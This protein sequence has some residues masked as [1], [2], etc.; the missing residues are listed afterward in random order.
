[1]DHEQMSLRRAAQVIGCSPATLSRLL[2][3]NESQYDPDTATLEAVVHWL[4][5][6]LSDFSPTSRPTES[7]LADV[8]MHLHALPN[9][10]QEDARTLMAVVKALY[11]QRRTI[12]TAAE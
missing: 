9:I 1:M 2:T 8:E 4:G 5:R 3:G 11:E 10:T 6:S 12:D 7:S